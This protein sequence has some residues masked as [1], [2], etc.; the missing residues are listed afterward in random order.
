MCQAMQTSAGPIY[1]HTHTHTHLSKC[2]ISNSSTHNLRNFIA[3]H[4]DVNNEKN[5]FISI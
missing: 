1:T 4:Q 2:F 3:K 5:A